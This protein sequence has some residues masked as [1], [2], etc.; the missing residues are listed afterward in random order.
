MHASTSNFP[1]HYP[2]RRRNLKWVAGLCA[3]NDDD[4]GTAITSPSNVTPQGGN[5]VFLRYVF[6]AL[7]VIPVCLRHIHKCSELF[8]YL[9][10]AHS[11]CDTLAEQWGRA[12]FPFSFYVCLYRAESILLIFCWMHYPI[13]LGI[14][15]RY[16]CYL[17]CIWM[18]LTKL[19]VNQ[20]EINYST[21]MYNVNPIKSSLNQ[22]V[23]N[24]ENSFTLMNRSQKLCAS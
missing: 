5:V 15:V 21:P 18:L 2:V 4:D 14:Y 16:D 11:A 3:S 17:L 13:P 7:K 10:T 9:P 24:S 6:I 23:Y 12:S 20:Y 19:I 22:F 1:F 8:M